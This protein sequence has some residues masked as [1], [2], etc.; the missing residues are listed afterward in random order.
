LLFFFFSLPSFYFLFSF[1]DFRYVITNGKDQVLKL[2]DIRMMMERQDFDAMARKD[3][4]SGFDYR[5]M[6]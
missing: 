4:N 3:F 2:W 6:V 1:A 5:W